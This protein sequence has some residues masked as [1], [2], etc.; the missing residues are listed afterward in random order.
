MQ[1]VT[2]RAL[3]DGSLSLHDAERLSFGSS[4]SVYTCRP[5]PAWNYNPPIYSAVNKSIVQTF[6][7]L[8]PSDILHLATSRFVYTREKVICEVRL[9][10]P[11]IL[12]DQQTLGHALAAV[13]RER[14]EKHW[15]GRRNWERLSLSATTGGILG[16]VP[17]SV[18][19]W[20]DDDTLHRFFDRA[21]ERA[22]GW[23]KT[24]EN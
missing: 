24:D 19:A 22:L 13:K 11:N 23:Q 4:E 10:Y 6:L 3:Q 17:L 14:W 18:G 2:N 1:S 5:I 21:G 16:V 20:P 9:S 7:K 8:L 15:R 12:E